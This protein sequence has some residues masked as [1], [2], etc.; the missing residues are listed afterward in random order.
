MTQ[1]RTFSNDC[2]RAGEAFGTSGTNNRARQLLFD[3]L[4]HKTWASDITVPVG[5]MVFHQ[6]GPNPIA[7]VTLHVGNNKIVSC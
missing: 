4:L 5:A 6:A 2:T 7:H 3:R 1:V